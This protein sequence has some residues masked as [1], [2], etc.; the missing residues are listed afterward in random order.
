MEEIVQHA[1]EYAVET[2]WRYLQEFTFLGRCPAAWRRHLQPT[3][4]FLSFSHPAAAL[5]INRPPILPV[6]PPPRLPQPMQPAVE[7]AAGNMEE[8]ELL[9]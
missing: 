1:R 2:F 7:H 9:Q 4:P 3:S 8:E 5:T 6:Q